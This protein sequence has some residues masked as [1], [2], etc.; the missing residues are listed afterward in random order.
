MEGANVTDDGT[1]LTDGGM[2]ERD[3]AAVGSVVVTVLGTLV[4]G[5]TCGARDAPVT[6]IVGE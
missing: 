4:L 1:V 6:S 3:G 2:I 5:G